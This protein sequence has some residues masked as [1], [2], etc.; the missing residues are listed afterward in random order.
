MMFLL[1][2][3]AAAPPEAECPGRV[4]FSWILAV[5]CPNCLK[6]S[7]SGPSFFC[8]RTQIDPFGVGKLGCITY[9]TMAQLPALLT[10]PH[11]PLY[12]LCMPDKG[13]HLLRT[14]YSFL[15]VVKPLIPVVVPK[16]LAGACQFSVS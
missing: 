9:V 6:L 16:L 11:Q 7:P 12:N 5:M 2:A 15:T 13:G 4:V 3:H 8:N 14:E 10:F 1:V